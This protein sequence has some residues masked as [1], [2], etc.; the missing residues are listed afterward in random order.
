M[1]TIDE[2]LEKSATVVAPV[3]AAAVF[4]IRFLRSDRAY[5]NAA[6]YLAD[7]VE[8]LEG[9]VR[10]LRKENRA[11]RLHITDLEVSLKAVGL[12]VPELPPE[13]G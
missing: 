3:T 9:E 5:H 6:D 12:D 8:S 7:R 1:M 10:A 11:M 2:V 13:L 4:L